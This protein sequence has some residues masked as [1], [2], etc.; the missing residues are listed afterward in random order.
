M[1]TTIQRLEMVRRQIER[2]GVTDRRVLTAMETVPRE[3]FVPESVRAR[4][5]DDGALPLGHGQTISQPYVV[6]TM[7]AEL[8]LTP[9]ARVLEVGTGSGYAAA[10]LSQIA[11]HVDTVER[12]Q[13][14]A[15][16]ARARLR[17]LGYRNVA[18][19]MGD[20]SSGWP[21][22]A[23]YDGVLVSAGAPAVPESLKAQLAQGGTLVIPVG[24]SLAEQVLV[25]VHR[26]AD[27][28]LEERTLGAVR[29]VPLLGAEGWSEVDGERF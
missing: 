3:A 1:D 8:A 19:H 17:Q 29:F 10:M 9:G 25:R 7:I 6:A 2:R 26:D 22:L 28:T 27:G 13:E 11:E 4:A 14:L 24:P 15:V 21:D 5:Y 18:V 16:A 23:P 12:I 20:G